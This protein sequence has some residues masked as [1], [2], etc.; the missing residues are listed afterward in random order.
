M[1]RPGRI[2]RPNPVKVLGEEKREQCKEDAG[3][4]KPQ[5]AGGVAQRTKKC[6]AETLRTGGDRARFF[7]V[8]RGLLSDCLSG[9]T[10]GLFGMAGGL[11][12]SL[13]RHSRGDADA[14]SQ[15]PAKQ[16]WLHRIKV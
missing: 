13:L 6:L 12:G 16:V 2:L 9:R 10:A 7:G 8:N 1:L 3:D 15:F 14:D 4:L 11:N 5:H